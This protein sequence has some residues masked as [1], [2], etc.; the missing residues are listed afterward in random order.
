MDTLMRKKIM[1]QTT[2]KLAP[3]SKDQKQRRE[4]IF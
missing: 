1:G 4:E 2:R 3:D